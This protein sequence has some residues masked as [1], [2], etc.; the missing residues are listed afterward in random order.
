[1]IDEVSELRYEIDCLQLELR[2]LQ[3]DQDHLKIRQD[4][5]KDSVEEC[6]KAIDAIVT[7]NKCSKDPVTIHEVC[8]QG[9]GQSSSETFFTTESL[10]GFSW[11]IS[12]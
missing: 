9:E 8:E 2:L 4:E 1:L 6:R 3:A 7:F 5:L 10:C 11:D 12:E